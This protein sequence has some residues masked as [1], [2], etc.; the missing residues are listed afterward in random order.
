M[1]KL[2]EG[3]IYK[4][5]ILFSI[6]M[7]LSG[8]LSQAYNLIDT[9]IAGQFLGESGLAAIGATSSVITFVSSAFSGYGVGFSVFIAQMYGAGQT[10]KIK[11]GVVMH[12]AIQTIISFTI[13]ALLVLFH[14]P[15]FDLLKIEPSLRSDVFRYFS[16]YMF[17][18]FAMIFSTNCMLIINALGIGTFPFYM[19]LLSAVVNITGNI[20]SVTV[21]QMGVAGIAL[22][23]ALSAVSVSV[24]YIFRLSHCFKQMDPEKQRIRICFT[25]IRQG[26]SYATPTMFQQLSMYCA[27]VILAPILNETGSIAIAANVVASQILHII[28]VLY[29]NA[30]RTLTNYTAQAMGEQHSP[31]EKRS[32]LNKGLRVGFLQG[33]LVTLLP[34]TVILLFAPPIVSAFFSSDAGEESFAIAVRFVRIFLPFVLFKMIGNLFHSFFRGVKAMRLVVLCTL[35]ATVVQIAATWILT[36][37]FG[38][39]GYFSGMVIAWIAETLLIAVFCLCKAYLPAELK[40]SKRSV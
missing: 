30:S 37:R 3:N 17:G 20:L 21:F 34:L 38:I 4:T 16:V 9:I 32:M 10:Q 15:I 14:E 33:L 2:T 13:S 28:C 22:S 11:R 31:S 27:G 18:L 7:I 26:I 8:L 1:K 36:P 35:F 5:F 40:V 39:N 25:E 29:Q 24:C 23:S 6:P 12:L 19:S